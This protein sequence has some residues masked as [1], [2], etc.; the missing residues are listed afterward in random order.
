MRS[1]RLYTGPVALAAGV[2]RP[3]VSYSRV[4]FTLQQVHTGIETSEKKAANDGG[5]TVYI[6]ERYKS[7]QTRR[8]KF[9]MFLRFLPAKLSP[10]HTRPPAA[11]AGIPQGLRRARWGHWMVSPIRRHD[12][13]L[14]VEKSCCCH[15]GSP[16]RHCE[17]QS[18][19]QRGVYVGTT[20]MGHERH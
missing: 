16:P 19:I 9:P 13:T 18:A 12:T 3:F 17:I 6:V 10:G 1:I 7:P 14:V 5:G 2:F 15:E 8:T 20:T 11:G 4:I